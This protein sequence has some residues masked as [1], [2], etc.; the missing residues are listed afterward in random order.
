M[1][2]QKADS[3]AISLPA[4]VRD[5]SGV[6]EAVEGFV[7]SLA[8][9]TWLGL[10]TG[11]SVFTRCS[12]SACFCRATITTTMGIVLDVASGHLFLLAESFQ[13][14]QS[15]NDRPLARS[16]LIKRR[17]GVTA[18]KGKLGRD[19]AYFFERVIASH[20]SFTALPSSRVESLKISSPL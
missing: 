14:G 8:V 2:F 19:V 10:R 18:F 17:W 20:A 9:A 13:E 11:S 5:G 6:S 12:A 3:T 7:T 16:C 4:G 15:V 1:V